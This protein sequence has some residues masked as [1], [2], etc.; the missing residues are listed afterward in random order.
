MGI[1][2]K[3]KVFIALALVVLAAGN[4]P[5][6][7]AEVKTNGNAEE[8]GSLVCVADVACPANTK[9]AVVD[10]TSDKKV[11]ITCENCNSGSD[12][13]KTD[14][15]HS[16]ANAATCTACPQHT[17]GA[18]AKKKDKRV[19]TPEEPCRAACNECKDD[20]FCVW[21]HARKVNDADNAFAD[22]TDD[23]EECSAASSSL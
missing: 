23:D 15:K 9:K 20:A 14:C 21:I 22:V 11:A 2:M 19:W 10:P 17:S 12:D 16:A 4:C 6:G 8:K 13:C 18:V 3:L 5:D 7:A 1:A